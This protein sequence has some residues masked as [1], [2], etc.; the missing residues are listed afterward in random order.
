MAFDLQ[1]FYRELDASY[2]AHDL[3]ATERFLLSAREASRQDPV[4]TSGSEGCMSCAPQIAVNLDYV[5]VCSELGCFYRGLSRWRESI[6]AFE[7]AQSEMEQYYAT[8]NPEYGVVLLNKAGAYRYM[9]DLPAALAAFEQARKRLEASDKTPPLTLAGLY[10]NIGLVRLD[11]REAEAALSL[12]DR[13]MALLG[14][15]EEHPTEYG[16]TCN[17]L[18]TAY[19]RLGKMEEAAAAADRAIDTLSALDGGDNCHYPAALNTRGL[20]RYRQ[21]DAAGALADFTLAAEKTRLCYGENIEYVNAC[22]NCAACCEWLGD[23]S[24]ALAWHAKERAVSARLKP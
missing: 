20:L 16:T 2:D 8:D 15:P 1:R 21:G 13:A 22:A 14:A 7:Q 3:A 10:N 9:G 6:A 23:A 12:F 18:A 17:N 5:C 11:L 19:G 4:I 24:G